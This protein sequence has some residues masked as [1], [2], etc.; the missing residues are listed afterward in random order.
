MFDARLYMNRRMTRDEA[1]RFLQDWRKW[2]RSDKL[3][4]PQFFHDLNDFPDLD[5]VA[6]FLTCLKHPKPVVR[7]EALRALAERNEKFS[8]PEGIGELRRMMLDDPDPGLRGEAADAL[9]RLA[10]R[11][12]L[13][14][15]L[16]DLLALVQDGNQPNRVRIDAYKGLL[17]C[18]DQ[19]PAQRP[20]QLDYKRPAVDQ[21]DWGWIEE[22]AAAR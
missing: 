21:L 10:G 20:W 4:P 6:F 17:H 2:F 14:G 22:V 15:I 9:G 18:S 13:P 5:P 3:S 8:R 19:V 1:R 11:Y 7:L 12:D 16:S